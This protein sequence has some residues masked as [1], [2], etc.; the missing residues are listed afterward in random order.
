L[1][2]TQVVTPKLKFSISTDHDICPHSHNY[3]PEQLM[4]S[5]MSSLSSKASRASKHPTTWVATWKLYTARDV[6]FPP[7]KRERPPSSMPVKIYNSLPCHWHTPSKR[8]SSVSTSSWIDLG[9]SA[10]VPNYKFEKTVKFHEAV[11]G[12]KLTSSSPFPTTTSGVITGL[13]R[14]PSVITPVLFSVL[15]DKG[16]RQLTEE[17]PVARE[18]KEFPVLSAA[19]RFTTAW[20]KEEELPNMAIVGEGEGGGSFV[21]TQLVWKQHWSNRCRPPPSWDAG[22]SWSS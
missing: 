13:L 11:I 10:W 5:R 9:S 15:V 22:N 3:S 14:M 20:D 12:Q 7:A 19:T 4:Y 8:L 1:C 2:V 16:G 6:A 18:K 17:D 21:P